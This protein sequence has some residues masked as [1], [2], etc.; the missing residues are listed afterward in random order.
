[1][2]CRSWT[3]TPGITG[4]NVES[5]RRPT[6]DARCQLPDGA[7]NRRQTYFSPTGD[8]AGTREGLNLWDARFTY[9]PNRG[10]TSGPLLSGPNS[11]ARPTTISTWTPAPAMPRSATAFAEAKWTPAV[12]YRLSYFSGDDPDTATYERWDPLLSGGN[13]E[14]WVQGTN[15][16]KV[17]QDSNVI[18]HRL[19]ARLR[20]APRV[21]VVPQLWAF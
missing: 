12:S 15:H 21:E 19:Q 3:P 4:L 1:M 6:A 7:A 13:G 14:Q 2:N 10:G 16:F 8:I 11:R 5:R 18:A 20:V 17:V 9:T